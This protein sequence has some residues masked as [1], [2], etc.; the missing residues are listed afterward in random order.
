M[1]D[2]NGRSTEMVV[3]VEEDSQDDGLFVELRLYCVQLLELLQNPKKNH[4]FLP[5]LLEL[6]RRSSRRSL[7]PLLDFTLSPLLLLFEAAVNCRSSR[8]FDTKDVSLDLH[9]SVA[10]HKVSDSV[11]E[12]VVLCLE[13]ILKKCQLGSI[14]Q[15]VV[16]LKKLANGAML[17]PSEASEEFREGVIRCFRALLLNLCSCSDD[18]CLCKQACDWPIL[19]S[20]KRSGLLVSSRSKCNSVSEEC[21]LAFLQSELASP[22]IGHWLSLLLKAA[23]IEAM[24]G[25]RGSSRIRIGALTTLR[26][27][28]AKVGT[29]DALAFY[30]PGVVSQ[31]GK[32]L[33]AS[34]SML[35]GAAGSPEAL[36]QAIRA[37]AEYLVIVL[38]DEVYTSNLG[39]FQ[40]DISVY[41]SNKEK[42]LM[43][44]VE[45]LRQ[46]PVKN[47]VHN[48]IEDSIESGEQNAIVSGKDSILTEANTK[49]GSLR[50]KRT[51]EW[52]ATTAAHI[53]KLLSATFPHICA[54]SSR[55]VKLGLL[56]SV[57]AL[58]CKCSCTL[59]HSRLMFLECLCALVC[60][61]FEDVS[62]NAQ[63]FFASLV[64]SEGKPELQSNIAE[65]FNRLV[66]KLPQVI[67]INEELVALLH[68]RKLLAV[69]YFGGPQLVADYVLQ[70]PVTSARFLDMFA[71]CFNQNS[72][73]AGSLNKLSARTSSSGF[74]H[75]IL[76]IKSIVSASDHNSES[77]G[78][79]KRKVSYPYEHV[80]NDYEPP[81]MPP[82]LVNASSQ[83]LYQA[84]S[85]V[86]RL[87]SLFTFADSRS[88][89]SYSV[90]T[91]ILLGHLRNLI[92]ELRT[93]EYSKESWHSWFNR[94][95][96]GKL[97]RQASTAAC[98]LNEMMFALSDEGSSYIVRMFRSGP[99]ESEISLAAHWVQKKNQ[100][101][102]VRNQLIDCVGT[103]LHEYLSPEIW[104]LPLGLSSRDQANEDGDINLHLLNDNA[105]LHQVI[106]EGIGVLNICLGKDFSTCGFLHQ[107]LYMLL[108]NVICSNFQV[109]RAADAVLRAISVAQDCQTVGH[110]VLENA[111]YVIDSVCR[112]LRHLDLSPHVPNVLSA[113]LSYVG[114]ADKILPL[115]EEPM[116][117]VSMELEIL[118]RHQHPNLTLSF[119]KAVAEIA[120][121]SKHEAYKLSTRAKTYEDEVNSK[122]S[123]QTSGVSTM[124]EEEWELIL[125]KF[126]DSKRYRRIVG[127]IA[128]SCL[129]AVTPLIAATDP[130]EC[131]TALDVVEDGITVLAKVEEA[132]K[133][134]TE[135]KET[136]EQF[137]QSQSFYN[138]MDTLGASEDDTVENRLLPAMNKIWP[139]FIACFRN[140]NL[141]AVRS[142]CRTISN[143]VPICG[144]DFFTRRFHSDGVHI[145]KLL[146]TSPFHK[147]PFSKEDRAPLQL[148]YRRGPDDSAPAET[149]NLKVQAAILDMIAELSGNKRS[150]PA[151]EAVLKRVTGIVVG[152]A[153]SGVK[154]LR[155][156]C[157]NAL[158]GL[159]SIDPDLVW[160]LLADVYYSLKEDRPRRPGDDFPEIEEVLPAGK[161]YLH[162]VYG[163]QSYGF[164]VDFGCVEFVFEKMNAEAERVL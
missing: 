63:T 149:S 137:I 146:T 53:N 96:S 16:I 50:V 94:I 55:K 4:A 52:L 17:S 123:I 133:R 135:T 88:E 105:M 84:L 143:V 85:G 95:S 37:M 111:D 112:Q 138:L 77:L 31:I 86:L 116:R 64:S 100:N 43:S 62:S 154:G 142:C 28:V 131:L 56:A 72:A 108:E 119:L 13:E 24:R 101:N 91:D 87:V 8:K 47:S 136:I 132:Y 80:R 38:G 76:E 155:D 23:D 45:K 99:E 89:G 66:E 141:V 73:F 115:L 22:A 68:V 161:V 106:I 78:F 30:L 163:G 109:S 114:V 140:K 127:S 27:L 98:I 57:E 130:A 129:V 162:E 75:S 36:D 152:I 97:V 120:K 110:L 33:N 160:L 102:S 151:L 122:I 164:D 67:L 93:K 126:N 147:K 71:L 19:P 148:P 15:M 29:A 81:S 35:S 7:Q 26:V 42:P 14:N 121:A 18:S 134:E 82:W 159:A 79:Q 90:L 6:L 61:D 48:N 150:A 104:D 20:E 54:H 12:A 9:D 144:G 118:G 51:A 59:K 34:R 83:K 124:K 10:T 32:V 125:F 92:Y 157:V 153:C 74:M 103:I 1:E 128:G 11:A 40:D 46:L 139:F 70:S 60:D 58:L 49:D 41:H 107:S 113:M 3:E 5:R 117:A 21:L 145:W 2:S 156:S 25:H 65:L 39:F 69:T 158:V 44:L